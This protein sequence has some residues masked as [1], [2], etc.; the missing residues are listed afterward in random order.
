MISI[1]ILFYVQNRGLFTKLSFLE[2][3]RAQRVRDALEGVGEDVGVASPVAINVVAHSKERGT[4][5]VVVLKNHLGGRMLML[6]APLPCEH[7]TCSA[8]RSRAAS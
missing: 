5:D 8:S 4:G 2:L 7:S 6:S 3:E 1:I